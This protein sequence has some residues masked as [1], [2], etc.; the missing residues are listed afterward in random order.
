ML[1]IWWSAKSL[2][3]VMEV[4]LCFYHIDLMISKVFLYCCRCQPLWA[5]CPGSHVNHCEQCAL[6]L[7]ST[8]VSIVHL[9]P[10][11]PLWRMPGQLQGV[12]CC[13]WCTGH[14]ELLWVKEA[15]AGAVLRPFFIQCTLYRC[16]DLKTE[17]DSGLGYG[18]H[19]PSVPEEASCW[20]V[21]SLNHLT[22][23]WGENKDD[24]FFQTIFGVV[25]ASSSCGKHYLGRSGN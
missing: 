12:V 21:A 11:Q 16:W 18:C 15:E 2:F 13:S 7:T 3:L 19:C 24:R 25:A 9:I 23:F 1:V 8:T 4:F 17:K 5:V 20:I 22:S 6:G 10:R 14:G